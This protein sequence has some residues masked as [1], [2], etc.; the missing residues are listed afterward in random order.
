MNTNEDKKKK[1]KVGYWEWNQGK[2]TKE[3]YCLKRNKEKKMRM[4]EKEQI[5]FS[6]KTKKKL[7]KKWMGG[8]RRGNCFDACAIATKVSISQESKARSRKERSKK[9]KNTRKKSRDT[10]RGRR[11]KARTTKKERKRNS[12]K[13][14]FVRVLNGQN[15]K[16][17]KSEKSLNETR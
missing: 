7:K 16:M 13:Q 6:R 12:N 3:K 17:V 11:K 1:I 5:C 10:G 9:K 15:R 2:E 14:V 4:T 8:R